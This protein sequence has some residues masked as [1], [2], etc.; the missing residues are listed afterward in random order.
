MQATGHSAEGGAGLSTQSPTPQAEARQRKARQRLSSGSAAAIAG[1]TLVAAATGQGGRA[2]ALTAVPRVTWLTGCKGEK[3]CHTVSSTIAVGAGLGASTSPPAPSP[4]SSAQRSRYYG[5]L[6]RY[7]HP[8]R[9]RQ[10]AAGSI[11]AR[12]CGDMRPLWPTHTLRSPVTP[13]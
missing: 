3:S 8:P 9:Y 5:R 7:P 12:G 1:P 11:R 2:D 10:M 4:P 6:R 13:F